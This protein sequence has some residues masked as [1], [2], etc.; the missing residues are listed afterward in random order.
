MINAFKHTS[1]CLRMFKKKIKEALQETQE[2]LTTNNNEKHHKAWM[3]KEILD[4]MEK[5]RSFKG[6]DP[7]RYRDTHRLIRNK[8]KEAKELWMTERCR[9]VEEL[10]QKHDLFNL[11][12]KVKEVTGKHKPRTCTRIV[13]G[14]NQPI[15]TEQKL[16]EVWTNY[17]RGLISPPLYKTALFTRCFSYQV[18]KLYN[19][20]PPCLKVL[21]KHSFKSK[22]KNM[23]MTLP[24]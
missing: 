22:L 7:Q 1:Y 14:E 16:E 6:T 4:L 5:R 20:F 9:E 19:G 3:T 13:D 18:F 12:K 21:Q 24:S 23:L 10:H 11:H 2:Q 17:I 15:L 8:N